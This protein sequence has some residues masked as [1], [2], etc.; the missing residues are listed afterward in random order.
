LK[1]FAACGHRLPRYLRKQ[2]RR[3]AGLLLAL[4]LPA[5][6]AACV[7]PPAPHLSAADETDI[8]RVTAYLNSLPR[9]EAH[10]LQSGSYGSGAGLVWLDRPGHLRIDYAGA[11]ARVM[12]ITGGR[13]LILDRSTGA[14]TTMALSRTPLGML[15]TPTISLSGAVTVASLRHDPGFIQ[16]TL[17]KTDQPAQ[18]SLTLTLA[19]RPLRLT[20]V[21]VT[22]PYHRTLTMNLMGIDPA[23]A[24]TPQLFQPPMASSGS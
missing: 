22:D 20:A 13:V 9:F 11:G 21:T 2:T 5:L 7:G 16:I 3:A 12:V 23:P 8:D 15:L 6:L 24:L 17:Q 18:G 10:F 1:P 4:A 14:T 19:D